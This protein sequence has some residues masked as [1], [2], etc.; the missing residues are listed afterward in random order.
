VVIPS[1]LTRVSAPPGALL[2]TARTA[3]DATS[4]ADAHAKVSDRRRTVDLPWWRPNRPGI[5]VGPGARV[6]RSD[7]GRFRP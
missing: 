3:D 5:N 2:T 4:S 1:V 6:A 7:E